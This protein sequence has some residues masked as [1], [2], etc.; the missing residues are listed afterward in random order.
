[1]RRSIIALLVACLMLSIH[2]SFCLWS[3]FTQSSAPQANVH[4][5]TRPL[6]V[7]PWYTIG[8]G[9]PTSVLDLEYR[10]CEGAHWDEWND[11]SDS[12]SS[13]ESSPVGRI[14]QSIL[15]DLRWQVT[16]NLYSSS[17]RARF[18]RI[19]QSGAY[20]RAIYY[21]VHMEQ[22][23]GAFSPDSLQLRLAIRFIPPTDQ[24]YSQQTTYLNFPA[25]SPP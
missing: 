17:G 7:Q 9:M 22:I 16:H 4:R 25:L 21:V 1:M 3:A 11:A 2:F 12:L 6:F 5:Y 13:G 15:D 18:D 23:R 19:Q 8:S 14:E 10:I 24:A 20:A